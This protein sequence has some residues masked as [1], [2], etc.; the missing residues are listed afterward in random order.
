VP[1]LRRLGSQAPS[2]TREQA[3]VAEWQ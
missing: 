2:L 1:R 3:K